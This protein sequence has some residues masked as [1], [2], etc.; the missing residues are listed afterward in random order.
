MIGKSEITIPQGNAKRLQLIACK[1]VQREAY[2]CAARSRNIVDIVL[3]PQGLHDEPDRLR[4]EVQKMLER[5]QDIQGRPYDASLLGYGL[6]SNGVVGLGAEIPIVVPRAHDCITLLLGSKERYARLFAEHPGTYWFS[7][8]WL[9][10]R[11][12]R[13]ARVE[14]RQ[15]SGLGPTY[16]GDD[17]SALVAKYGEDNARYL[18]EF[19][20]HWEDHY[21][22]GALI[23]FP[24]DGP[25]GLRDRAREICAEKGWQFVTVP[26][27][28]GLLRAGLDGDWTDDRFLR[29]EPGLA[30]RPCYDERIVAAAPAAREAQ[31]SPCLRGGSPDP[32]RQTGENAAGQETRRA[33]AQDARTENPT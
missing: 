18:A 29:L 28:L 2:F 20:S 5:T 26:G 16:R 12:K 30:V 15:N 6:C 23:E 4:R 13:G 25:L 17:F 31:G 9:E 8:G 32:P 27:D 3:M 22:R 24:F 11:E 33:P 19:M 1:V 10:C 21:T 7:S 14:P